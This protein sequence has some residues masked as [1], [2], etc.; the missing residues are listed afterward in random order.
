MSRVFTLGLDHGKLAAFISE[1]SISLKDQQPRLLN[2]RF[3][4]WTGTDCL[5]SPSRYGGEKMQEYASCTFDFVLTCIGYHRRDRWWQGCFMQSHYCSWLVVNKEGA[6]ASQ[7]YSSTE[8]E[9]L[10]V[11]SGQTLSVST[12][13]LINNISASRA[14]LGQ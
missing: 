5:S 12:F 13:D 4:L 6:R 14:S 8:A 2:Y 10:Q 1:V 3:A 11:P 9:Q 7:Q